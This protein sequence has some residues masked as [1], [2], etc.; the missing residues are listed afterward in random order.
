MSL[1]ADGP[2][3]CS[4]RNEPSLV[5][6]SQTEPSQ[7]VLLVNLVNALVIGAVTVKL[8][9]TRLQTAVPIVS[10]VFL[11]KQHCMK[12]RIYATHARKARIAIEVNAELV[13]KRMAW[14]TPSVLVVLHC[15]LQWR[16]S[17]P[18]AQCPNWQTPSTNAY[19]THARAASL[20]KTESAG[21]TLRKLIAI[22]MHC[23]ARRGP[24]DLCVGW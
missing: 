3:I 10:D 11:L 14:E 1:S 15:L 2:S 13:L 8:R 18:T 12:V 16:V 20:H 7:T 19:G 9:A 22:L 5:F 6:T 23:Y 17:G 4:L 24:R 21:L